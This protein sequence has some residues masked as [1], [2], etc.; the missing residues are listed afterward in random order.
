MKRLLFNTTV[1]VLL[2]TSVA[3]AQTKSIYKNTFPTTETTKL[4]L[5]LMNTAVFIKT[6]PDD[7][8]HVNFDLE[9]KNHTADRVQK[10]LDGIQLDAQTLNKVINL[11]VSSKTKLR[12][13]QH[14]LIFKE[15]FVLDDDF[16]LN[17]KKNQYKS[18]DS[19][20]KDIQGTF[21][22]KLFDKIKIVGENGEKKDIDKK[23][24]RVIKCRL[25]IQIPKQIHLML[26]GTDSQIFIEDNLHQRVDINLKKGL[27]KAKKIQ[28]KDASLSVTD[29]NVSVESLAID[30]LIIKD[31]SRSLFGSIEGTICKFTGSRIELGYIGKEVTIRDYNSKIFFYNFDK[32]FE[33]LTFKGEYTELFVYDFEKKVRLKAKGSITLMLKEGG[34]VSSSNRGVKPQTTS[35]EK[36]VKENAYGSIDVNLENGVL[37]VITEQ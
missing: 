13:E 22:N 2:L 15:G 16:G 30:E 23:S 31:V 4:N 28:H 37:H 36:K 17:R 25:V 29:A 18:Q 6:S 10:V 3:V 12:R 27:F 19:I 7:Q 11:S 24:A 34:T 5:K 20:L 8:I 1:L 14:E 9:F 26:I 21:G 33:A 35:L 32:K